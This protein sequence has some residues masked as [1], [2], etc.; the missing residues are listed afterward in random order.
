MWSTILNWLKLL[1]ANQAVKGICLFFVEWLYFF[2]KKDQAKIEQPKEQ[3]KNKKDNTYTISR[4]NNDTYTPAD[5]ENEPYKQ[6]IELEQKR[7]P[8]KQKQIETT[9]EKPSIPISKKKGK[10]VVMEK[11]KK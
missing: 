8:R 7:K 6:P 3:S 1:W 4:D 11:S 10:R 2:L 5:K 9:L